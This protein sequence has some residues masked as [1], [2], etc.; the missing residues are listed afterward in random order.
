MLFS[1][2]L[3]WITMKSISLFLFLGNISLKASV[4]LRPKQSKGS[5]LKLEHFDKDLFSFCLKSCYCH[6]KME[7]FHQ[8]F[9][10]KLTS[11]LNKKICH[12][13]T[14]LLFCPN[15]F[16]FTYA[17]KNKTCESCLLFHFSFLFLSWSKQHFCFG[18]WLPL[19]S[20]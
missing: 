3:Y 9:V 5:V 6:Q 20:F 10:T 15:I 4:A 18:F 12:W 16:S 19:F 7:T 13:K 14:N 11:N 2:G 17:L 8:M 1:S